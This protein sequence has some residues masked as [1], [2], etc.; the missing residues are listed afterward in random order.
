MKKF[1][2]KLFIICDLLWPI[3]AMFASSDVIKMKISGKDNKSEKVIIRI[4]KTL[5][6]FISLESP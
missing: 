3:N 1:D 5:N 2:F 4:P 6:I